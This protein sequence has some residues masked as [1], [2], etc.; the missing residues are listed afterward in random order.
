VKIP[1]VKIPK[2]KP[3]LKW[4][5]AALLDETRFLRGQNEKFSGEMC[6]RYVALSR[7][8]EATKS[9]EAARSQIQTL[10]T[11]LADSQRSLDDHIRKSLDQ[12]ALDNKDRKMLVDQLTGAYTAVVNARFA[13]KRKDVN[14]H[15]ER[16]YDALRGAAGI[17]WVSVEAMESFGVPAGVSSWI[18]VTGLAMN[19]LVPL[20]AA[21]S[22]VARD[23]KPSDAPAP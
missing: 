8:S 5:R 6:E 20:A 12:R 2:G 3:S 4:S 16:A 10:Q 14:H 9:L 17:R 22:A 23:E 7:L 11:R 19:A 13:A 15:L 18:A 1:K 21:A